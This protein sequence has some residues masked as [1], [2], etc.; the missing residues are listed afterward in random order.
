MKI[1]I[2]KKLAGL[3]VPAFALRTKGDLGIGDTKAVIE[4]IDFCQNNNFGVL[5][6]LP[7]N[8]TGR[9]NSPY[10]AI[11]ASALDPVYIHMSA[12]APYSVPGL[13]EELIPEV[14]WSE[15][16]IDYER[17]KA[18]KTLLLHQ[19]F[20]V[21]ESN[22]LA[23]NALLQNEFAAFQKDNIDWL[24]AYALFRTIVAEKNENALWTDWPEDLRSISQA[25][26]TVNTLAQKVN[27]RF[28]C[29]I[30]W[31]AHR[32]WSYVKSHANQQNIKLIGDIPF[33]VSRYSADVWAHPDLFDLNWSGGAPPERFFQADD[34]TA[35]WGQ[36]WGIPLYN[37]SAHERENFHW[38][39]QRVK[40]VI[41]YFHGF[42]LDHVLGFYRIYAFPWLPQEN[43]KFTHLSPAQ[44]KEITGGHL[45]QFMP[46]DDETKASA[47]L[48][49]QEG[50]AR[51][52][53]ILQAAEESI[54]IAEDLGVVPPY[55]RPS[56]AGLGIPGFSIPLFERDEID[57]SFV[58]S[59][60]LPALNLATYGTHD[61]EPLASYYDNL[62]HWWHGQDGSN[63]WAEM[64]KL[65]GF[66]HLD[67]NSAPTTY[68]TTL[69]C[70]FFKTLFTCPCWLT[71]LMITDLLG[72]KQRFN[73]PG[74]SGASNWSE[75]LEKP[76]ADYLLDNRYAQNINFVRDLILQ[77]HRQP[78]AIAKSHL[79]ELPTSKSLN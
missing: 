51:L 73:S 13:V 50:E 62:V 15:S 31:V 33:G 12:H 59:E 66:L 10:N 18:T 24:P 30:Q 40:Q 71:V 52:A 60:K 4:A 32:Q 67:E 70:T 68:N 7:I 77:T 19:A 3:L 57:R 28:Y 9:D 25:Q 5:Q 34:F 49:C 61:N 29:Y 37:W 75:R 41:K 38:W 58:Q 63:G 36:N 14:S 72:T 69:A 6:L 65:M 54:V 27:Q 20:S 53:V 1:D 35:I 74:T 2:E 46:R 21:F 64:Q 79:S 17:V 42:R 45:P 26:I 43:S 76:L 48:N 22:Q 55:V 11:S 8:E 56:L 39:R 44:V 47:L 16:V 78:Y 23:N